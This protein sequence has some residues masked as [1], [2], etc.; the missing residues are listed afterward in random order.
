MLLPAPGIACL[1]ALFVPALNGTEFWVFASR[2]WWIL[3]M[4]G[5]LLSVIALIA[6]QFLNND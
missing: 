4:L 3:I 5:L 6:C 2:Y 1:V